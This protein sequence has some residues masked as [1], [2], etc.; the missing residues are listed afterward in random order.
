MSSICG[1]Q[2]KGSPSLRMCLPSLKGN[3]FLLLKITRIGKKLCTRSLVTLGHRV[4]Q[5][6]KDWYR[7]VEELP[8]L[9]LLSD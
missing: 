1:R 4:P 9:E 7:V 6:E 8:R 5:T 3:H 2:L